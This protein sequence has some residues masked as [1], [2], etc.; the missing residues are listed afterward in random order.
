MLESGLAR[1][2]LKTLT[3]VDSRFFIVTI[4]IPKYRTPGQLSLKQHGSVAIEVFPAK[5]Q[6]QTKGSKKPGGL[7]TQCDRCPQKKIL[8]H[9]YIM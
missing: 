7:L 5:T 3:H 6:A 8:L 2:T 9:I 1:K 4:E